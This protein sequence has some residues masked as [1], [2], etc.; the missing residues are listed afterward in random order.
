M[1]CVLDSANQCLDTIALGLSM[2]MHID[3]HEVLKHKG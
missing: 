2:I 1:L 3:S